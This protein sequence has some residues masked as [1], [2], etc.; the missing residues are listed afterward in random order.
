MLKTNRTLLHLACTRIQLEQLVCGGNESITQ[1]VPVHNKENQSGKGIFT[2]RYTAK[3]KTRL[4]A[5][6]YNGLL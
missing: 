5:S 4:D 2:F 1:R 3:F 6:K